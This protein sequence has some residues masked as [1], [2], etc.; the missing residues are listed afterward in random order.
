MAETTPL[1]EVT[2]SEKPLGMRKN[3][4][5][6]HAPKKAFRPT[7]GLTS[8]EKR[9]KERT[10]MAQMKAKEN[11]MKTE[12]KEERQRKVDA[13]REKRA[14]KAEKERYEKLAEKMHKK[15]VERLKRKEKRNKLINS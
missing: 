7:A 4:K 10:L 9:T 2:Q 11:E 15:R 14:K 3:G 8:Y 13:I 1:P 12:K 6:W 5:Q